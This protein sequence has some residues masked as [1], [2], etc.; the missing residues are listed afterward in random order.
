MKKVIVASFML[1]FLLSGCSLPFGKNTA[2]IITPEEAKAKTLDFVNKNLVQPGNEVTVKEISE[3]DGLYKTII[4]MKNGQEIISYIS[5]DGSK[6]FPQVIDIAETEKKTADAATGD[7]AK[8]Q[9]TEVPKTDKP[10]VELFVMAFCP[11]GVQ[12]E[13]AMAPVVDL[14]GKKADIKIRFIASLEGTDLSAVKSLHGV[15]EG[16]EDV[17]QLC[18][19]KNYDQ[20]ILWQ[21]VAGIN[22]N[23]VSVYS[24]GATAYDACWKKEAKAAKIDEKKITICYNSEGA[25][26]IQAESVQADKYSVSGSPTL[27]INGTQSSGDRTADGYKTSIC[28]A[29]KTA[30]SECSKTLS[31]DTAATS[32]GGC[33]PAATE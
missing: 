14:L 22:A 29:F 12:A 27:I 3:A 16:Q 8:A 2:K 15:I 18:V 26:L 28:A 23:C 24:Q 9:P 7:N 1:A 30:P 4:T 32:A 19:A 33:A 17:R 25:K 5:K 21:Y 10:V 20:K 6:F 13:K 11:Y 31:T